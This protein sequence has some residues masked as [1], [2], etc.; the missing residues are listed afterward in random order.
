[1]KLE[2]KT[3]IYYYNIWII[4]VI[5]Q[6]NIV[7]L[8]HDTKTRDESYVQDY[9]FIIALNKL[10]N[11][12]L[13][14]RKDLPETMGLI[15]SFFSKNPEIKELRDMREHEIEYLEGKGK[16]QEEY[17]KDVKKYVNPKFEKFQVDAHV[18]IKT[19]DNS[20]IIIGGRL[21]VEKIL[22]NT[23]K[24]KHDLEIILNKS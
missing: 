5:E 11:W 8:T 21:E 18:T 4:A 24:L 19:K 3:I 17:S 6:C 16:K 7:K 2:L 12:L 1:M 9:F 13:K 10:R 20:R 23:T 15:D 22:R 14:M